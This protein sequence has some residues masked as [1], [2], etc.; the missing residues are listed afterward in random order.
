MVNFSSLL[1]IYFSNTDNTLTS[2]Q[3]D[4]SKDIIWFAIR[5]VDQID[6]GSKNLKTCINRAMVGFMDPTDQDL[7]GCVGHARNVDW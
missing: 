2:N 5:N 6:M 1:M 4:N 7:T 3:G